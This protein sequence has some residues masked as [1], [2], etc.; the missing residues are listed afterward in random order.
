MAWEETIDHVL[1]WTLQDTP[2]KHEVIIDH[3]IL[4]IVMKSVRGGKLAC[5]S[6]R[7]LP[8]SFFRAH[9]PPMPTPFHHSS[10]SRGQQC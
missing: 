4:V 1:N 9:L 5:P 7:P 8:I 2:R 3:G 10:A 6:S